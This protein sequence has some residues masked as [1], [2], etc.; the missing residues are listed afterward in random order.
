MRALGEISDRY[1][2]STGRG[3]VDSVIAE[4]QEIGSGLED[5]LA[6]FKQPKKV[7]FVDELPR[8]TMDKVQ[9]NALRE[10]YAEAIADSPG[11]PAAP[12][13]PD[14]AARGDWRRA[15]VRCLRRVAVRERSAAL[16]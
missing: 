2:L 10:R 12:R 16:L 11:G 1:K 5:K 13:V 15:A 3:R 6:K 8:N 14:A 4:W 7:F 9:K